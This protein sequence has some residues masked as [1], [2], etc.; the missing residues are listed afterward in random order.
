MHK[1]I[2]S[3]LLSVLLVVATLLSLLP[4]GASA[5]EIAE[6]IIMDE[7]TSSQSAEDVHIKRD[8]V[9]ATALSDFSDI[10]VAPPVE[11]AVDMLQPLYDAICKALACSGD[12]ILAS[13]VYV[14]R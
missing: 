3:R 2:L 6:P 12:G 10:T 1:N 13:S 14:R 5:T 9:D 4:L 11:G 8:S 7:A